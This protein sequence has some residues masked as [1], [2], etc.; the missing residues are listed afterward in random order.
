M[1]C[2]KELLKGVRDYKAVILRSSKGAASNA[3]I[4]LIMFV[5]QLCNQATI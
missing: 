5:T 2:L 1:V 4:V 3:N